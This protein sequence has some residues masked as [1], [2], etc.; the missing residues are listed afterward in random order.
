MVTWSRG[1]VRTP[2]ICVSVVRS[3]PRQS[4]LWPG[5]VNVVA[6]TVVD[7]RG[8]VGCHAC[9]D[10]CEPGSHT[11]LHEWSQ[12]NERVGLQRGNTQL[13]RAHSRQTLATSLPRLPVTSHRDI[14]VHALTRTAKAPIGQ[15][16]VRRIQQATMNKHT[17]HIQYPL[18]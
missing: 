2:D 6:C 9:A 14:A 13:T 18:Q 16:Y 1:R 5:Q 8:W 11:H 12:S 10:R 4:N 3:H 17:S 7:T 15:T